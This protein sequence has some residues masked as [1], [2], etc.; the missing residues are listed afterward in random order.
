V[1]VIPDYVDKL[2]STTAT[3]KGKNID[4]L[5]KKNAINEGS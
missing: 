5:S 1:F 4:K 2:H 3:P